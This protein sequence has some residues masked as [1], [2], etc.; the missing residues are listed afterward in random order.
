MEK[1]ESVA[2]LNS[3]DIF[4]WD[5]DGSVLLYALVEVNNEVVMALNKLGVSDKEIELG[6]QNAND[7]KTFY[8]V[9]DIAWNFAT[10]FYDGEFL[11][12]KPPSF[13]DPFQTPSNQNKIIVGSLGKGKAIN[14]KK[15]YNLI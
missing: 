8:D 6:S 3:L 11:L 4:E 15:I 2:I 14:I 13:E 10:W 7:G 1:Q 12:E 9:K 5:T